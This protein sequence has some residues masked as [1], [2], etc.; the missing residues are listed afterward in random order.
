[1]ERGSHERD[2]YLVIVPTMLL[3]TI[4]CLD[5]PTKWNFLALG[6][7]VGIATLT[8]SEAV[9]FVVLLGVVVILTTSHWRERMVFVAVFPVGVGLLSFPGSSATKSRWV[10]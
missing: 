7:L 5:K 10:L 3:F 8:R 4:W 1:V 9:N 6:V 2:L